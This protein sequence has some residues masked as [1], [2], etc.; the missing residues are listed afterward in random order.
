[1]TIELVPLKSSARPYRPV[2]DVVFAAVPLLPA[3]D[4]SATLLPDV[5]SKLQAPTSPGAAAAAGATGTS[6][7]A[8]NAPDTILPTT[9]RRRR[10]PLVPPAAVAAVHSRTNIAPPDAFLSTA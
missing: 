2:V 4:V 6:S 7:D 5:S 1:V 8:S 3:P 9:D 10:A